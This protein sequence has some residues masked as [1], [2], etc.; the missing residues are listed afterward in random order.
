MRNNIPSEPDRDH[1]YRN[2]SRAGWVE[3][4]PELHTQVVAGTASGF[5]RMALAAVIAD[6]TRIPPMNAA[7]HR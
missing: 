4:T 1:N 5:R 6:R 3:G 2:E 7:K